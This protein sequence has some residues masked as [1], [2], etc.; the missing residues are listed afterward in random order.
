LELISES[1]SDSPDLIL[2]T[3]ITRF[4]DESV[5]FN[6]DCRVLDEDTIR[7]SFIG[8][9]DTDLNSKSPEKIK[10]DVIV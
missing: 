6:D 8:F 9:Q 5:A 7:K 10:K 2:S 1:S 4:G 3:R